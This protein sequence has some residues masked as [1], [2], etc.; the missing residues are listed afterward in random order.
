[1]HIVPPAR[2]DAR[3]GGNGSIF[4]EGGDSSRRAETRIA[5]PPTAI[6]VPATRHRSETAALIAAS[7]RSWHRSSRCGSGALVIALPL[8]RGRTVSQSTWGR[9]PQQHVVTVDLHGVR[10]DRV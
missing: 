10:V 8:L 3:E 4:P 9:Q 1:M 6:A 5:R 7:I 2:A